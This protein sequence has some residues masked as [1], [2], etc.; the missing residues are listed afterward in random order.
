MYFLLLDTSAELFS[1]KYLIDHVIES[2]GT[3]K[4][5]AEVAHL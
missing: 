1:Y 5:I 2:S 4:L 3:W